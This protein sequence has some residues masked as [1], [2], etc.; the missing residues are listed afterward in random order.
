M[1]WSNQAR[2]A[3]IAGIALLALLLQCWYFW[4]YTMDDSF[5]SFR[6]SKHIAEGLG[7]I[8]NPADAA[9]PVEGYTSILHVFL[10]AG[11]NW[12]LGLSIYGAAKTLGVVCV[13]GLALIL[14]IWAVRR[15]FGPLP[16]AVLM[17]P[18]VLP[19]MAANAVSGMETGLYIL[20]IS[21]FVLA[22]IHV[23]EKPSRGGI[24]LYVGLPELT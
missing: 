20:L 12:A 8:W 14:A 2:G 22:A 15:G 4:P 23:L 13:A 24:E 1:E 16:I 6:Y 11:L 18:F 17:S 9:E 21:L 7:P 5:I 19:F 10:L 3:S